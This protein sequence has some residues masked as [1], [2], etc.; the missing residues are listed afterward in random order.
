MQWL[1]LLGELGGSVPYF[2]LSPP[3]TIWAHLLNACLVCC[4]QRPSLLVK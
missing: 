2:E 3:A 1:K 4:S